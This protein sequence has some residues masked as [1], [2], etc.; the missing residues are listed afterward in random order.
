[1]SLA[2]CSLFLRPLYLLACDGARSLAL[3]SRSGCFYSSSDCNRTF[4]FKQFFFVHLSVSSSSVLFVCFFFIF[5]CFFIIFVK[6]IIEWS[7]VANKK[8]DIDLDK[9]S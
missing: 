5:F 8:I 9:I 3:T 2:S 4:F 7:E 1:M 6:D